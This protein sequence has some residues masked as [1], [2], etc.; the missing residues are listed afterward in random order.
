M[1]SAP[2]S[3]AAQRSAAVRLMISLAAAN[4][5]RWASGTSVKPSGCSRDRTM[6]G[7]PSGD[8]RERKCREMENVEQGGDASTAA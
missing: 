1:Y 7:P 5:F 6:G 2:E 3:R 4:S 8:A